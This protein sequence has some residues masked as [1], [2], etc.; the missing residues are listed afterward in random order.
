MICDSAKCAVEVMESGAF[1]SRPLDFQSASQEYCMAT[2]EFA[3]AVF[4]L[5]AAVH[6]TPQQK[7]DKLDTSLKRLAAAIR[8]GGRHADLAVRAGGVAAEGK[9]TIDRFNDLANC[10]R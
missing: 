10:R 4:D 9:N 8:Q 6:K 5:V 2:G 7:V 3:Y 1:L